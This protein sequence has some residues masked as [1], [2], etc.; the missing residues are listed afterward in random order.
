[1]VVVINPPGKNLNPTEMKEAYT[2]EGIMVNSSEFDNLPSKEGRVKIVEKLVRMGAGRKKISY[3]LKDWGIS[4]QRYWG[5]PIP[6]I[7]CDK[8]GVIPVNEKDLPVVLP[9]DV[10][11]T[12]GE[13]P[14]KKNE[15]FYKTKCY[16]CGSPAFRETDTMDTFVESSWYFARYTSPDY[17]RAP[18]NPKKAEYWLPVDQYIGGIEHAILHLLYAR[19]YTK[20]LRDIGVLSIDEPFVNLLTQGMVIKDGAKMSK[21][22]GNI[23]DPDDMVKKY[24]ADTTRLFILFAAPPERDLEWNDQGVEG[25]FRFL[26]RV[27]RFVNDVLILIKKEKRLD[28]YD[29]LNGISK[30]VLKRTHITIKKVTEDIENGFH[31]NTAISALMEFVN[32]LSGINIEERKD[33]KNFRSA[34]RNAVEKL[35]IMLSVFTPH[36]SEELWERLG[37]Q[38]SIIN[39]R[40][41][42]WD[43]E[44]VKKEEVEIVLQINGKVRSKIVVDSNISEEELKQKAIENERIKEYTS[45]RKIKKIIVVPG[46]LVNIVL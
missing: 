8:C 26:N 15:N 18:F 3:K 24:G 32:F 38:K 12:P 44:L 4:R 6:V 43:S 2:E 16:K 46:R 19:F 23:V 39:E 17:K 21:S 36:I 37:N 13:S 22:K 25:A 10:D 30:E 14:L 7:Y 9:E 28:N 20:V 11:L 34:L 29:G 45:T 33:D 40:W 42:G 5:A 35:L 27:W 1:M 31:F 41:P